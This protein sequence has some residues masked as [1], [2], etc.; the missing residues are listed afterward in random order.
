MPVLHTQFPFF[1]IG[2]KMIFIIRQ[3]LPTRKTIEPYQRIH[4]ETSRYRLILD[5]LFHHIHTTVQFQTFVEHGSRLTQVY[6]MLFQ[7]ILVDNPLSGSIGIGEISLQV[8]ISITD[9]YGSHRCQSGTEKIIQIIISHQILFLSPTVYHI[10][11]TI[12]I[13]HFRHTECF[14]ES[15]SCREIN[16]PL[17]DR[18]AFFSRDK[19]HS[20][21]SHATI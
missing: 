5:G 7:F 16:I 1:V 12:T 13:L 4:I 19:N 8:F 3:I 11:D 6:I 17:S 10:T 2:F 21:S 14:L 20:V 9:R 15:E 18:V